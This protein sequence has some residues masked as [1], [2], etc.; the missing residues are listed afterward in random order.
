MTIRNNL[1]ENNGK[2]DSF[3]DW[4]TYIATGSGYVYEG[5]VVRTQGSGKSAGLTL[6]ARCTKQTL[7]S[8]RVFRCPHRAAVFFPNTRKTHLNSSLIE[9][10]GS[11]T[12]QSQAWSG[13]QP[14]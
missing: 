7:L 10:W 12:E 4:N 11:D 8:A 2:A 13:S 6:S 9:S 5:N 1:L 3:F 14:I